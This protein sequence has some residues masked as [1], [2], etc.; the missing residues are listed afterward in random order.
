MS[1]ESDFARLT[2][3]LTDAIRMGLRQAKR[4]ANE[5]VLPEFD[6]EAGGVSL[7]EWLKKIDEFSKV[8]HWEDT[9]KVYFET[10]KLQGIARKWYDALKSS[11]LTWA[12]FS[13]AIARQFSGEEN[14]GKLWDDAGAYRSTAGQSLIAYCFEKISRIIRLNLD[15]PEKKLIEYIVHGI[16]DEQTRMSLTAANKETIPELTRCLE[17]FAVVQ[18]GNSREVKD[19][20]KITGPEEVKDKGKRVYNEAACYRCGRVEHR[21]ANCTVIANAG[22]NEARDDRK[23]DG[24]KDERSVPNATDRPFYRM[25]GVQSVSPGH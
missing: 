2:S 8:F 17:L 23:T 10:I 16:H 4:G 7:S 22:R 25:K 15:I 14:F 1:G 3:A 24:K 6:P 20:K 21:R 19:R 13:S 9:D 11:P 18:S 12:D 5:R